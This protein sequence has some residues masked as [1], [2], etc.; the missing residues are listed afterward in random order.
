MPPVEGRRAV[1]TFVLYTAVLSALI[2]LLIGF[3]KSTGGDWV[4]Y[5]SC[6]MWCPGLAALLTCKHLGRP[7]SSIAWRWGDARYPVAGY[8]TPLA[9]GA[10]IYSMIWITGAG[11]FPSK[12]FVDLFTKD[13]GFG[14]IP[15][16]L[17][18]P[19]YFLYTATIGVIKNLPTVLGEEIGW[20]GFLVPELSRTHRFFGTALI[21]SIIWALWHYPLILFGNYHPPAPIWFYLPVFTVTIVSIG[22]LWAWLRLKSGSVWPC[23]IL[24]AAHNTFIHRF[25]DPLTVPTEKSWYFTTEFGIGMLI[26]GLVLAVYCT[27]RGAEVETDAAARPSGLREQLQ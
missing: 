7:I 19:C 14:T 13:F 24:H 9:Y 6:L 16:V 18:I 1:V 3:S 15:T 10:I 21:S 11:G 22:F 2:Y 8:V 12:A 25:F 20:R 4:D 26:V 23:V 5:V 27:Q 17:A